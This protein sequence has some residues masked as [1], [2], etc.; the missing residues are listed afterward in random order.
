MQTIDVATTIYSKREAQVL[1]INNARISAAFIVIFLHVSAGVVLGIQNTNS[2]YWWIGDIFDSFSKWCIPVFVMI[3]GMLLLDTAK[4]EPILVFYKRRLS[5]ILIPLIF[6][7]IFFLIFKYFM[8]MIVDGKAISIGKLGVSVLAGD[9]F[10][11]LWYL[12]MIVGLYLFT[13]FFRRIVKHSSNNELLFLCIA[14]FTFSILGTIF[15]FYYTPHIWPATLKFVFYLPY[16]LAGYL[17]YKTEFNPPTW[18]IYII[19]IIAVI[20]N[21]LGYHNSMMTDGSNNGYFDDYLSITIVPMS[22]SIIFLLKRFQTPIID[23]GISSKLALLS[24]GIYLI[25]PAIISILALFRIEA[26]SYN[27]LLSIPL[28]T[29]LVFVLSLIASLIIS[30]IPVFNRII[31]LH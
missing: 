12:Y 5:R 16:F 21:S 20:L 3:S 28:I 18:I 19:F 15:M 27:P 25:H 30:K 9:P 6:W 22:I 1:W 11:H 17:I 31:G 7:T 29:I 23:S 8:S 24:F 13:P 2:P 14:L 26:Q 4:D 10:Y